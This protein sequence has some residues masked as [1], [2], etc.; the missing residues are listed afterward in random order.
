MPQRLEGH[1]FR[2]MPWAADANMKRNLAGEHDRPETK[3]GERFSMDYSF[4]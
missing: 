4:L 3:F 1:P 2:H